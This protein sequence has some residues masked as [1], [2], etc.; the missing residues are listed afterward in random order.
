MKKYYL[1]RRDKE[2]RVTEKNLTVWSDVF[3]EVGDRIE[4]SSRECRK[5][6]KNIKEGDDVICFDSENID[7]VCTATV[8]ESS[9]KKMQG[10]GVKSRCI[11]LEKVSKKI[12][13][14]NM[15]PDD[16]PMKFIKGADPNLSLVEI[17]KNEYLKFL[18]E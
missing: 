11:I 10:M 7:L 17:E 6:F 9:Y 13:L 16:W 18:G 12:T 14:D 3:D 1:L 4:I 5:D 2:C 15:S 8:I